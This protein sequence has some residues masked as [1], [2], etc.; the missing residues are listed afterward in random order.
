VREENARKAIGK[1]GRT[2]CSFT[3]LPTSS[4]MSTLA[5]SMR[6][7]HTSASPILTN[8]CECVQVSVSV[9]VN[10]IMSVECGCVD[11]WMC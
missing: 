1:T 7:L 3:S 9:S 5:T 8:N 2:S 11:V 4:H 6:Y 10:V